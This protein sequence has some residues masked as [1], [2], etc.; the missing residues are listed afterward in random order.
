MVN[1]TE[2]KLEYRT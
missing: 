2:S 1:P